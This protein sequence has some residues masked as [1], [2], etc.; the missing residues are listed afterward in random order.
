MMK[1]IISPG[2]NGALYQGSDIGLG[3]A[4]SNLVGNKE[5]LKLWGS[6]ARSIKAEM[7]FK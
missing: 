2:V 1:E 3:E 5:Q 4:I 7:Q 6:N